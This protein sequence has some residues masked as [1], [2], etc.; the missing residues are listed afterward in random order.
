MRID[1]FIAEKGTYTR[2]R[3]ALLVKEGAVSVNGKTVKAPSY[4][5]SENDFIEIDNSFS[6]ND[7]QKS[8][9]ARLIKQTFQFQFLHFP[10]FVTVFKNNE[11]VQFSIY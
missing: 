10:T 11:V 3:A 8:N 4:D 6:N 2:S 9:Y 1:K 5:V 7:L